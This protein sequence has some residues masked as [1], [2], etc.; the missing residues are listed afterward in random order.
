MT[1]AVI[2]VILELFHEVTLLPRPSTH[3]HRGTA[4]D[5]KALLGTGDAGSSSP[6]AY[7]VISLLY[8]ALRKEP[9]LQKF[10]RRAIIA[11]DL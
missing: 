7:A 2:I 5:E 1:F 10:K 3:T 4:P 6:F 9:A 11:P 8:L